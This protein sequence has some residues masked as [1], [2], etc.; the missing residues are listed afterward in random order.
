MN[1]R[2]STITL[3]KSWHQQQQPN[4]NQRNRRKHKKNHPNAGPC[5]HESHPNDGFRFRRTPSKSLQLGSA[6]FPHAVFSRV[7][8]GGT[9]VAAAGALRSCCEAQGAVD[10]VKPSWVYPSYLSYLHV[11]ITKTGDT[12]QKTKKK[13]TQKISKQ[14]QHGRP[15]LIETNPAHARFLNGI[16]RSPL[17]QEIIYNSDCMSGYALVWVQSLSKRVHVCE[18]SG[19]YI[20]AREKT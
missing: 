2:T 7:V 16:M 5:W 4:Q 20:L 14:H 9:T 18:P 15:K 13:K 11:E 6:G 12:A 8:V 19:D 17:M 1:T 10:R 3:R